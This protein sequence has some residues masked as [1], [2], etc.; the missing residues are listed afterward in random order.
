MT[1]Q[2]QLYWSRSDNFIRID[3]VKID[4]AHS[5]TVAPRRLSLSDCLHCIHRDFTYYFSK[6]NILALCLMVGSTYYA[7]D[8]ASILNSSLVVTLTMRY[9]G[10]VP[11]L[12]CCII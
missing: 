9:W 8:Y 1:S 4:N 11:K 5:Q 6:I 7:Q 10:K 12:V 3:L 2:W